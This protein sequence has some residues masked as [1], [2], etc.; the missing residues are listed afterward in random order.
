MSVSVSISVAVSKAETLSRPVSGRDGVS[1]VD[2]HSAVEGLS[3]PLAIVATIVE[4]GVKTGNLLVRSA[5]ARVGLRDGVLGGKLVA[6]NVVVVLKSGNGTIVSISIGA[7]L[8]IAG[9]QLSPLLVRPCSSG[10]R[11]AYGIPGGELMP[12][13][14]V[15]IL[16]GGGEGDSV[17]DGSVSDGSIG[18]PLSDTVSLRSPDSGAGA[19]AVAGGRPGAEAAGRELIPVEGFGGGHGQEGGNL[20]DGQ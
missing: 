19:V 15:A 1:R 17:S 2:S 8:A 20:N 16:K 6:M 9:V 13:H 3:A 10:V 4:A 5:K 7:P 14:I 12:V 11:L 18:A